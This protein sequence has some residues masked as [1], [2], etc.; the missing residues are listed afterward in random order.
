MRQGLFVVL[1]AGLALAADGKKEGRPMTDAEQI[2]GTWQLVSGERNGKPWPDAV[3]R[4]V[5]L[6]FAGDKLTTRNGDR[7]T[8][9]TFAL[10][11][12][13]EPRGIDLDMGGAVGQGIY[14]LDGDELTI[15]HGEVGDPR[16]TG[17]A[18]QEGAAFTR[19]VLKRV[20]P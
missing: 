7:A 13:T 2:Q 15:A 6:V 16:P 18:A 14:R 3:V 11:P 4:N 12:D 10:H 1:V 9:G 17:F 20:G 5:R 19:M 8:E